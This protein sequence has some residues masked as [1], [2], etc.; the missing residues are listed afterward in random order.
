MHRFVSTSCPLPDSHILWKNV[1]PHNAKGSTL[2]WTATA[3]QI[4]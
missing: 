3:V 4:P 2:V 1:N